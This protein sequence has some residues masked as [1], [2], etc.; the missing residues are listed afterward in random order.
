M[1]ESTF[2][3]LIDAARSEMT[4][5]LSNQPDILQ[6]KLKTLPPSEIVEF[7]RIFTSL[8]TTPTAGI[9][10]PPPTSSKG[11]VAMTVSNGSALVSSASAAKSTTRP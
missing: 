3:A 5:A 6:E 1:D 8:S 2:W 10:G 11:G 9:F 7:D 4:P